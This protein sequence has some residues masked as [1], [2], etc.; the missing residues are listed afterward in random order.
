MC[1]L[2]Q[3]KL[4]WHDWRLPQTPSDLLHMWQYVRLGVALK[5]QFPTRVFSRLTNNLKES[6]GEKE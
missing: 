5:E 4:E 6:T 2:N 3:Q 1:Q